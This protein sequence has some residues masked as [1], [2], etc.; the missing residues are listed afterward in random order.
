MKGRTPTK[1]EKAWL[2]AICQI[3]CIVCLNE[4]NIYTPCMPHHMDGK[5]KPGAHFKT[6]GLCDGHHQNGGP[7]VAFHATGKKTWE[8]RYGT[9][10]ALLEQTK[11]LINEKG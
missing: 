7:G 9:Q 2:D 10:K 8:A 11:M 1:E 6:I 3:G 5:T 4:F